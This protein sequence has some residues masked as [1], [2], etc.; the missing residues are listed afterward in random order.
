MV[1]LRYSSRQS[2]HHRTTL[3]I[4]CED[5][6]LRIY[7]AN[8]NTNTEYWMQSQFKPSSPLII[9]RR[10]GKRDSRRRASQ[11]EKPKFPIDFFENCQVL[12][13]SDIDVS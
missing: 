2:T 6:S 13:S 7:V 10:K 4:L 12:Q 1:T 11:V 3:I 9:L 5:G 8:N